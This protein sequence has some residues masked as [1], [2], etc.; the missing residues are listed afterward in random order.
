MLVIGKPPLPVSYGPVVS[1]G[2][3]RAPPAS[4]PISVI[5][6]VLHHGPLVRRPP[7][8]PAESVTDDAR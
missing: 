8:W 6:S 1:H 4:V 2:T 3:P 7:V 5:C